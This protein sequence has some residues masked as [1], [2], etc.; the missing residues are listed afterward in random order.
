M[1]EKRPN[2]LPSHPLTKFVRYVLFGGT[3]ATLDFVVF[4]GLVHW[5]GASATVATAVGVL[6]G[7]STS[8]FLNRRYTFAVLDRLRTRYFRFFAVGAMG[9]A[10]SV[11]VVGLLSD[12]GSVEPFLAKALSLPPVLALQFTVNSKWSFA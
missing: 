3:A 12:V 4:A 7:I 5:L 11:L 1:T 2:A 10:L 9:L 8:F 6:V